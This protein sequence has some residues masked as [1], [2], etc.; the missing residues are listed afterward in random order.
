MKKVLFIFALFF[1]LSTIAQGDL[2]LVFEL[3]KVDNDQENA[4]WDTESF[5]EKI[6][7]S[8]AD[9]G[10]ILGWDLWQLSPGGESQGYQYMTVTLF[11]NAKAMFEGGNFNENLKKAYP[12][13]SD[14][15]LN[16][17][18]NNTASTRDLDVRIYLHQIAETNDSFDMPLGTIAFI[19]FMKVDLNNYGDYEKAEM[20]IFQ[21]MHQ[22]EVENGTLASWGL[23]RM[24]LPIGSDTY[25]SHIT[26]DM[27]KDLDQALSRNSGGG[28]G[29]LTE[30]QQ[31]AIQ[32][33]IATRDMKLVNMGTLV[34]KVRKN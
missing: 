28:M 34:K 2:Y 7:Q 33:G 20:D 21:P 18:F 5:W 12:N 16:K 26:V 24:M 10:D 32:D 15:E 4:Y 9:N 14:D 8:R 6:H 29:N 17:K 3:M 22:K 23:L 31:K 19:N 13:M 30:A 25:A 27:F 1:S 11:D